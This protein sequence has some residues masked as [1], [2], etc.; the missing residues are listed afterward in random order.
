MFKFRHVRKIA[1][2]AALLAVG[3]TLSGCYG[4]FSLSK[5]MYQFNGS[6]GNKYIK[7]LVTFLTFWNVYPAI[8][9]VDVAVLN[10][11]EFWTGSNPVASN[12]TKDFDQKLADGTRLQAR[13]LA[14]GR[15]LVT[16]TPL[17]GETKTAVLAR[18]V[19]G[20]KATDTDGEFVA[21][22]ASAADGSQLLIT[23]KAN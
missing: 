20:I 3:S 9:F 22:V 18:E 21:K 2:L 19:D 17:N 8:A 6:I 7:S 4:S 13:N 15:L 10:L 5:K 14:D 11:V 23:P 1:V 16:V 12:S